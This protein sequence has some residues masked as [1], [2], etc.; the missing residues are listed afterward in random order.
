MQYFLFAISKLTGQKKTCWGKIQQDAFKL[1]CFLQLSSMIVQPSH[2]KNGFHE[3]GYLLGKDDACC[4]ILSAASQ[5]SA[6]EYHKTLSLI[7]FGGSQPRDQKDSLGFVK[8]K[9]L[10]SSLQ[11]FACFLTLLY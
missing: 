8:R 6:E 11:I 2:E 9:N 1:T 4:S 10:Q 3:T 7:S 5:F